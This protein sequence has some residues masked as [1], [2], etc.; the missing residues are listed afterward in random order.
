MPNEQ[1]LSVTSLHTV[2][3]ASLAVFLIV[4]LVKN[5]PLLRWVP[6]KWVAVVVGELL[7]AATS[8]PPL[9]TAEWV[10]LFVNGLQAA[11]A[12]I[13]GYQILSNTRADGGFHNKNRE[14]HSQESDR[15]NRRKSG[16]V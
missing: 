5:L 1:M 12:A 11:S 13:G 2:S 4:Q 10:V 7:L 6:T 16:G 8:T 3:G 15:R 14:R 9:T